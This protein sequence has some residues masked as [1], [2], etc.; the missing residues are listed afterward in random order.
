MLL[1]LLNGSVPSQE[2][3]SPRS[4]IAGLTT[5][6]DAYRTYWAKHQPASV[7]HLSDGRQALK[8]NAAQHRYEG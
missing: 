4:V 6:L 1:D 7:G 8:Q 2:D 3:P 5:R